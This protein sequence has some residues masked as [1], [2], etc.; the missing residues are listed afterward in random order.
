VPDF[1]DSDG[2]LNPAIGGTKEFDVGRSTKEI[3]DNFSDTLSKIAYGKVRVAL[4]RRGKVMA[5]LLPAEQSIASRVTSD[6][7][8]TEARDNLSEVLN[9]VYYGKE[10]IG[11][12][13]HETT[14][15]V[16]ISPD[17]YQPR[18]SNTRDDQIVDWAKIEGTPKRGQ[19]LP[20]RKSSKT[21]NR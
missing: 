12:Q 2:Y 15:A 10:I 18:S 7:A 16:V 5:L 8:S 20:A 3:R 13:R 14:V 1:S 9:R 4:T 21:R 17:E 6:I 19:R 11:I